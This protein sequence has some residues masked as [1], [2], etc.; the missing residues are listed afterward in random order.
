MPAKKSQSLM[1][2]FRKA[3]HDSWRVTF[4][5]SVVSVAYVL[6][7]MVFYPSM[8]DQSAEMDKLLNAYPKEM[9]QAFYG[10]DVE[11]LSISEPGNYIQSQ[12]ITWMELMMGAIVIV[13]AFNAFT[14]AERDGTLDVMMSLPVSRRQYFLGRVANS[15]SVMLIW[16]A[17]CWVPLWLSTYIWPQFDVS[18]VRLALGVFGLFWPLMVVAGFGYLLAAVVPSSKHFA[19]PLAYLFLMGSYILYMFAVTIEK[20]NGFKPVFLFH[21]YNGGQTI[22][23]G[24]DW[25]DWALLGAVG[26][27]YFA[28]AWWRIDKKEF[29][30]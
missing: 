20:L 15:A 23:S 28:L 11:D 2:V 17:A 4:W 22:R 27:V 19:G 3:F 7:I 25:G 12:F 29:G 14:N 26:L 24:A 5:L 10:G 6:L 21:Y 9:M 13:Q 18:P 8:I 16:L 30:V 1:A